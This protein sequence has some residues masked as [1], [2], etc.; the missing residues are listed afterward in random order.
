M[1]DFQFMG[2][3]CIYLPHPKLPG[4]YEC[5]YDD[6]D[7]IGR[8]STKKECEKAIKKYLKQLYDM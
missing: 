1:E 4:N 2:I 6:E 5:W 3:W 8:F 7:F